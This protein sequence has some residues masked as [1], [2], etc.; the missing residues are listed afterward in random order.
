[1]LYVAPAG[2]VTVWPGPPREVQAPRRPRCWK[3]APG[4]PVIL[5]VE[6][7]VTTLVDQRHSP[8]RRPSRG[9][10]GGHNNGADGEDLALSA[11]DGPSSTRR[12]GNVL[13]DLVGTGT[14]NDPRRGRPR[15]PWQR[16]AGSSKRKAPGFALLGE[17][18][19]ELDIALEFKVV[20][21][22]GLVGLPS[23]GQVQP[24]RGDLAGAA[25][26]PDHP[27]TK[28]VPELGVV[29][30]GDTPSPSPTY[31]GSPRAPPRAAASATSSSATSSAVP[32][33]C[34]SSTRP[35]SSRAATRSTTWT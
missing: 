20:A 6:P 30:A 25:E 8:K 22:I 19:E 29:R 1:M 4:G 31:L 7:D 24:Y 13:A 35:R 9:E 32:R 10:A 17:P 26:D 15:R 28:L 18:G 34:T 16:G 5:R 12:T 14:E 2:A 11:P 21:D 33:W 23:A 27:S 3:R